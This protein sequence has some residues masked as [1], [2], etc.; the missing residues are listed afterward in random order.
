[1]VLSSPDDRAYCLCVGLIERDGELAALTALA[2]RA[3]GGE[4]NL[5]MITGEAGAGKTALIEEFTRQ[6]PDNDRVLWG[7]CDPLATPRPLGPLHDVARD[8]LPRTREAL[9]KAEH[10]YQMFDA[11]WD[12][13]SSQPTIFVID[14]AHWSDQGTID[15]LRHLLRRVGRSTTMVI[16]TA[17]EG[18]FVVD[19]DPVRLLL[20][21]I[22]RTENA[23]SIALSPL[24]VDG[25]ASMIGDR[26]L[27][28]QQ[29]HRRT[30]GNPFFV[31]QML[32]HRGVDLPASVR[33]AVLARTV[34]LDSSG[35]E[36]LN[37]LACA[38]GA[39]SETVIAELAIPSSGLQRLGETRLIQRTPRG[40]S[41][42]HDLC[43][44]AVQTVIPPGAEPALH[45][46]MIA[47]Y[48]AV[49]AD[50]AVIVHHARGAGDNTRL[51]A[52]AAEAGRV[53]ARS[54]A[55]QQSAE[56]FRMALSA[57]GSDDSADAELLELL[58]WECYLIDR[59]DEAVAAGTRAL[60]LR[61][62]SHDAAGVSADHHALAVYEWY[63]A[64]RAAADHHVAQ[65]IA[66]TVGS[67]QAG[68]AAVASGHGHA[69]SAFLAMQAGR[70]DDARRDLARARE[71]ATRLD[72]PELAARVDIIAGCCDVMD[73]TPAGRQAVLERLAHAPAHLDEIYSSGYSN[74][75][76]LDVE[77]RRIVEAT[78]LLATGIGMTVERD[79][80]VCRAWQVGSRG[81][82]GLIRGDWV[83]AKADCAEVLD[84]GSAPLTKIW[85]LLVSGLVALRSTGGGADDL[86]RAWD[87]VE[88]YGE[89]LR[90]MPAASALVERSWLT[91]V[92]D[93]RTDTFVRLLV[94]TDAAGLEWSRGDLAVWLRR[95]AVGFP[96]DAVAERLAEP[97]RQQ[98]AGDIAGAAESFD[99]LG[100]TYE[101][102]LASVES[103]NP[104]RIARGLAALDRLGAHLVADKL[105][106]DL[107]ATG[108]AAVPSRRR[109]ASMAH[110]AGLTPRQ[111]EVL[112]L[113]CDGLTNAELAQRLFLSEKTVDHH[114]SAILSRLEVAGRREAVRR[115]R[116]LGVVD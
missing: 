72:S 45:Q 88:R 100:I 26:A 41:F 40:V 30:G 47:A 36:V 56:F 70:V 49:G 42:R 82:L 114:V 11:V 18:E 67:T 66:A 14:D 83:G 46:R 63:N 87:L 3:H 52:A 69:M 9:T 79:L 50:P 19:A 57:G 115:A 105:R 21:D 103:G 106:R 22:A 7:V 55:H 89:P 96:A 95:T 32:A 5:V 102:A 68:P 15:L 64:N 111:A 53:A 8:L 62:A 38:P 73:G 12:D 28:A 84:S 48:D 80:P 4:G 107:R 113:M 65:S 85:P 74:L 91:G 116:A 104:D 75:T 86:E 81:R 16:I 1:M 108:V 51:R 25:V 97:Y 29:L 43:R 44:N 98:L 61:T 78:D 94:D 58:A 37:L 23:R 39:I 59:L 33:D 71:L 112:A 35:W 60:A 92:A 20:G 109:R 10:A 90:L 101:G 2:T 77:Q 6:R 76:Y 27:D 99:G 24:S 54:G 17:R 31:D 93:P 34:G 13:F 110:P